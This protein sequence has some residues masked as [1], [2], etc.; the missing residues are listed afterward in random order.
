MGPSTPEVFCAHIPV[1]MPDKNYT[2]SY[3]NSTRPS[4]GFIMMFFNWTKVKENIK[5]D[6]QFKAHDLGYNIF[7]NITGKPTIAN[8]TSFA[9]LKREDIVTSKIGTSYNE[10][11]F[12]AGFL[13]KTRAYDNVVQLQIIV[14]L[15]SILITTLIML[16][17]ITRQK[18]RDLLY[19]MMPLSAI[20]KIDRGDTVVEKFHL[21]TIFFCDIV[22]FTTMAGEM[23]PLNVMEMLNDLYIEFDKLT[24][25]HKVYKVET[26]GDCFMAIGGAPDRCTGPLAGQKITLFAL[27][28]LS[29]LK[30]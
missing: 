20:K 4:W 18:H 17:L 6:E 29:K 25:K 27:D 26:I 8:S 12:E 23:T 1:N 7:M 15:G 9:S 16:T 14:V 2:F 11:I 5:L 21:V 28:V 22:G 3:A 24:I 19:K 10:W 13:H 30:G